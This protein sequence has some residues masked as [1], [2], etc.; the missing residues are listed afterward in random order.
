[1]ARGT[2]PY[3]GPPRTPRGHMAY[4]SGTTG[5]PKGV[6]RQPLSPEQQALS[7]QVTKEALG[8][9]PGVRSLLSAPLYH[10]APSSFAQQSLLQGEL[11]V[12][13]EKFDAE[14]TLA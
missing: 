5:R 13:E 14:A 7:A 11:F 12:L 3:A 2:G 10:S 6:R 9:Y 1:M 8:I 4:T